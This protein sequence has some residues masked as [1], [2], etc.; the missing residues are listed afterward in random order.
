[1]RRERDRTI[2]QVPH[3]SCCVRARCATAAAAAAQRPEC[4]LVV[5]LLRAVQSEGKF[6][7]ELTDIAWGMFPN[8]L[9]FASLF[10][11][12][13]EQI[14]VDSQNHRESKLF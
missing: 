1:M 2:N 6:D 9:R 13:V 8:G 5:A 7:E 14:K 4:Y 12:L 11:S 10:R 3:T